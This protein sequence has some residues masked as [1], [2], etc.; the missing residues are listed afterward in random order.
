MRRP[1]ALRAVGPGDLSILVHG[2]SDAL[3]AVTDQ[4]GGCKLR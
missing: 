2:Y 1:V 4:G 3:A